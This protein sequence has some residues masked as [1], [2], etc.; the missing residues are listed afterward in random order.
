MAVRLRT[1]GDSRVYWDANEK[2]VTLF[3]YIQ[4]PILVN[5]GMS[6][7]V[8]TGVIFD[9]SG[10]DRVIITPYLTQR[11][12]GLFAGTLFLDRDLTEELVLIAHNVTSTPS[13]LRPDKIAYARTLRVVDWEGLHGIT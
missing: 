11:S 4:E 8:P 1:R 9:I 7:P 6:I 10:D 2:A 3:A 12:Q 5:P 13:W